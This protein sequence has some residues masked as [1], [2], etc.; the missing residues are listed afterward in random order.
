MVKRSLG[1]CCRPEERVS[2]SSS[3]SAFILILTLRTV[4]LYVIDAERV[5]TSSFYRGAD[6]VLVVFDLTDLPSFQCLRQWFDEVER[7]N[8]VKSLLIGNKK[9]LEADGRIATQEEIDSLGRPYF[10]CSALTG[11]GVDDIFRHIVQEIDKQPAN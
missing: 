3:V 4:C 5:L 9:D 11:E 10:E 6:G 1:A 8:N 7:F 2:V